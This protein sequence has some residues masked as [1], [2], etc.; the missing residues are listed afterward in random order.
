LQNFSP[1]HLAIDLIMPSL[2]GIGVI[3]KL[4]E[5][6]ID[7]SVII[8]S[9]ADPRVLDAARRSANEHG[10][11]VAGVLRKPFRRKE[12]VAA[13]T[14]DPDARDRLVSSGP[15]HEGYKSALEYK[16]QEAFERDLIK[17]ALQPKVSLLDGKL[18]GF[19]ALARW[20]GENGLP[21]EP[22]Q[23]VPA[24]ESAGLIG[25]LTEVVLEKSLTWAN[26]CGNHKNFSI[27]IN[28]SALSLQTDHIL[29]MIDGMCEEYKFSP[30]RLIVEITESE[31]VSHHTD[32]LDVIT[33]L[34]LRKIDLS[35]D[36]FGVGYS[37]LV[38]LA[39]LPFSELKIDR[40]FI[41]E[42]TT[43]HEAHAI[44]VAILGM[45]RGL[46][47]RTIAEGIE[48]LETYNTLQALGCDSA[49]GFFI[50]RPM[51]PEAASRW[52]E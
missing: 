34:R 11:R 18:V 51:S 5:I 12:L 31:A 37:S 25:R 52:I 41:A 3:R 23:F 13:L 15:G 22:D 39:R 35:I 32:A 43:S 16:I 27:A 26:G 36:D 46:G 19:E 50:G 30:D 47:L 4:S 44:V 29:Q 1:T 20:T 7:V 33:Q 8:V 49:Q 10:L 42:L 48:D 40:R 21:I 14:V 24:V 6:D 38:Q 45:A 28:V 9:G 17:I 2:D